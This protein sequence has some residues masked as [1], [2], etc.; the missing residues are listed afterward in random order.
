MGISS[1]ISTST[2]Q[3]SASS[4]TRFRLSSIALLFS[5]LIFFEPFSTINVWML[6]GLGLLAMSEM[7]NAFLPGKNTISFTIAMFAFTCLSKFYWLQLHSEIVWWL[8]ALLVATG[9]ILLLLFLPL[10]D[11]LIFPATIMGAILLQLSWASGEVWLTENSLLS[12]AGFVAC[13]IML[14]SKLLFA[15][16]HCRKPFKYGEVMI[17]GLYVFALTLMACAAMMA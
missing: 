12:L 5:L 1:L 7:C 14:V 8:P 3:V 16:H 10:L 15:I 6:L 17:S 2:S 9:I 11:S 13:L 4:L